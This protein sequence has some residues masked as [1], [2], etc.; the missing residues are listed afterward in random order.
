MQIQIRYEPVTPTHP[1]VL[2]T[3]ILTLDGLEAA[4]LEHEHGTWR[5]TYG[6]DWETEETFS[7]RAAAE[8]FVRDHAAAI[9]AAHL[10]TY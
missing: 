3:Y 1:D 5:L 4:G 6:P 2:A 10:D 8:Q 7:S 9:K